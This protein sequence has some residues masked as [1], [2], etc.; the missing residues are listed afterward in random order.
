MASSNLDEMKRLEYKLAK[1]K[2][3]KVLVEEWKEKKRSEDASVKHQMNDDGKPSSSSEFPPS[4]FA[5]LNGKSD[6]SDAV[7]TSRK[8]QRQQ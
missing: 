6:P 3:L 8:R 2:E 7:T 1:L 4:S 5:T